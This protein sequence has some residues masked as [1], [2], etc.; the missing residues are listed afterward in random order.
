ML[1]RATT[2]V[3]Q[4][5]P[6]QAAFKQSPRLATVHYVLYAGNCCSRSI[7]LEVINT[8]AFEM[9]LYLLHGYSVCETDGFRK[10]H[11]NPTDYK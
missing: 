8:N 6:L 7:L 11:G 1:L 5:T 3:L 10:Q 4:K 2:S 9:T